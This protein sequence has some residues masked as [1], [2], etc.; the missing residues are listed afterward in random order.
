M[1]STLAVEGKPT[2]KVINWLDS[3]A[4]FRMKII[5]RPNTDRVIAIPD[6]FS[7]LAGAIVNTQQFDLEGGISM[8]AIMGRIVVDRSPG[9]TEILPF[10]PPSRE[11]LIYPGLKTDTPYG[12]ESFYAD[13]MKFLVKGEEAIRDDPEPLR[14]KIRKDAPRYRIK[15][16]QL[17]FDKGGGK[18]AVCI[19]GNEIPDALT[20]AH[21]LYGHFAVASTLHQLRG[22]IW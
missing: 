14:K 4:S 5:H 1:L 8:P 20:Y 16:G 7:R 9:L 12:T 22:R 3:L 13:I 11:A 18:L 17:L 19:L 6:G 2:G 15:H 21:N 10:A